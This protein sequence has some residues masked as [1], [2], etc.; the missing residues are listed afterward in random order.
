MS[1]GPTVNW[2]KKLLALTV[3]P[4]FVASTGCLVNQTMWGSCDKSGEKFGLQGEGPNAYVLHCDK[5]E[6][7]PLMT[8][9]EYVDIVQK[10][11]VQIK[12][13][14][15]RP[16]T[17]TTTTTSTTTTSTTTI[18]LEAPVIVDGEIQTATPP[19][20][21]FAEGTGF[22]VAGLAVIL[23][24]ETEDGG[25]PGDLVE[26]EATDVVA[27]DDENLTFEVPQ[28]PQNAT[29]DATWWVKTDGGVS[30]PVSWTFPI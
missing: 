9:Q 23:S 3:V 30:A 4:M 19:W 15:T 26:V 14:P 20:T 2:M 16:T 17:T 1:K 25:V 8:A 21:G 28:P 11:P 22:S 27:T 18:P 6:W 24:Y 12:P 13:L 10:K 29:G 5:G 7:V